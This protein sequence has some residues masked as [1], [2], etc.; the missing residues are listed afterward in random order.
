[1]NI[2]TRFATPDDIPALVEM[3]VE[4]E[5]FFQ[6]IGAA[7]SY[8]IDRDARMR[9]LYDIHFGKN[10]FMRTLLA[11]IYD[12]IVGRISFYRGYTADV[13]PFYHMQLSGVY[14]RENF[15]GRGIMGIMFTQLREIAANENMKMIKWSVWGPNKNAVRAYEKMG[16]KRFSD[17]WDEHFMFLEI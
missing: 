10:A 6:N 12:E 9:D 15:R 7:D 2:T 3:Q 11:I 1:M 17:A 5:Q 16:A 8:N 4:F 13:P 14:I